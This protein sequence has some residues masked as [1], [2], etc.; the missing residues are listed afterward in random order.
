MDGLPLVMGRS[1][2]GVINMDLQKRESRTNA[3]GWPERPS[4]KTGSGVS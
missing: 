2:A 4:S 3:Y 1:N